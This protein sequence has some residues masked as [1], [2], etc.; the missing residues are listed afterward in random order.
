MPPAPTSPNG[1]HVCEVEIDPETG[2][3]EF[4]NYVVVMISACR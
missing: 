3:L 1:T 2:A 4:Q